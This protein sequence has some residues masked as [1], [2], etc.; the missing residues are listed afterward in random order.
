MCIG[1]HAR[2]LFSRFQASAAPAP[3]GPTENSRGQSRLC[4]ERPPVSKM[5]K[6]AP[7][8]RQNRIGV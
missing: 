5:R 3:E 8:G 2:Y 7:Q 6:L 1:A 4:R